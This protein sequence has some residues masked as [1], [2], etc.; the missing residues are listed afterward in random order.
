MTTAIILA[1]GLGTRLRSVVSDWPKAMAPI[2]GRPFLEY[3]MDYWMGQGVDRFVL[4]VGYMA[5]RIRAHFGTHYCGVEIRY[6][7][8]AVPLGTGGGLLLALDGIDERVL[9]LNG[10]TFFAVDCAQLA[11]FH[12][13]AGAVWSIALHRRTDADRYLGMRLDGHGEVVALRA[14]S[15]GGGLLVNGG[16]YL[17]DSAAIRARGF[18]AGS[19]C[20]LEDDI[21]PRFIAAGGHVHGLECGG[22]FIDIGVPADYARAAEVI[23]V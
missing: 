5:D 11:A 12:A 23:G 18:R 16:V 10:D 8:E 15:R 22:R 20:S 1:G 2:R 7:Q 9:V 17:I 19:A 21:L 4:S 14:E 6:A 13:A 3:Q